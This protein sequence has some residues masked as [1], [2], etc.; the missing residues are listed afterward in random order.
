[1]RVVIFGKNDCEACKAAKEKITYFA[2]KWN[3]LKTTEIVFIDMET[4]DG[5][6]EGAFRDVCEIPTVVI[7]DRG[8]EVARWVK[9]VPLSQEFRKYLAQAGMDEGTPHQGLR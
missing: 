4:P 2:R 6:A 9:K 1:M 7:E 5:L 3:A 8:R